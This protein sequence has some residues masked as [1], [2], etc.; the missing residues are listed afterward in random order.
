ML[1]ISLL[2]SKYIEIRSI[3]TKSVRKIIKI[4]VILKFQLWLSEVFLNNKVY[5]NFSGNEHSSDILLIE[6]ARF[7]MQNNLSFSTC[8]SIQ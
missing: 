6:F 2:H 1:H 5:I 7:K 3:F 8:V 4:Y